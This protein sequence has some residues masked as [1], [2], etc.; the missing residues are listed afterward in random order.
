M[1]YDV[2]IIGAGPSGIM[3]AYSLKKH[4]S[5]L[6][7]LILEKND[8][9]GKKLS[10][11]GNGRCNLGNLDTDINN[12]F[13]S[14]PLDRFKSVLSSNDY[15]ESIKEVGI[16]IKEDDKRL[17]PYSNQAITVCK[18]F[19]RYLEY[20]NVKKL[21]AIDLNDTITSSVRTYYDSEE[22]KNGL[23]Y[24]RTIKK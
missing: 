2:V 13:S 3:C 19:E 22:Y 15:L 9:L 20:I 5:S 14:S 16:L 17:Y 4:N 21:N 23:P 1:K 11:T 8:K 24:R 12:Y 6:R 18:S 7:V 10:M